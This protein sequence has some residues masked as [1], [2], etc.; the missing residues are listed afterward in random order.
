[1][2]KSNKA[3]LLLRLL[4]MLFSMEA[5]E[6]KS[7]N[8]AKKILIVRQ[9]NQFGDMLATVPLFRA[10]KE[11]YPGLELTILTSPD[12]FYAVTKN[13][14]VDR[15][16]VFDKKKLYSPPYFYRLLRLLRD[17][18]D[19]AIV[20]STVSLSLTSSLIA[21]FANASSRIGVSEL[22]GT[23]NPY[24]FLFDRRVPLN[25]KKHPDQHVS[26]FV[27][28]LVRPFGITTSDCSA[29]IS[30][31]QED[32][33]SA[34]KFLDALGFSKRM[35]LVG[36]H[37]GAGKPPNRWPLDNYLKISEMLKKEFDALVY[38][39]GS[40]SDREEIEFIMAHSSPGS[41]YFLDHGIPE[42]AALISLSSLFITND[43][44]V[45]H[46]AGATRV[47]QLSLFGPTNPFN[48]APIGANK[49]FIRK[50]DIISEISTESVWAKVC[51][52]LKQ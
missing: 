47:P 14:Y 5:T 49:Y 38:F 10:L 24:A 20:P 6:S 27:L 9:H 4:K 30:F 18:Y 7:I 43:T 15:M 25:W 41:G 36:I 11:T 1:M 39:T 34:R 31:D 45:M 2:K 13:K 28:D 35:L 50:S 17:S 48:W 16:F 44:G 22:N 40:R 26:D 23:E 21:R 8:A 32:I 12:N 29:E 51:Q 46:V 33:K 3:P 42:L 52:I 37:A 19:I